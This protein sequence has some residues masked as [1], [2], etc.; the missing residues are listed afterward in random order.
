MSFYEL[1]C[2]LSIMEEKD[3]EFREEIDFKL[4][5]NS[6]G[7]IDIIIH[8]DYKEQKFQKRTFLTEL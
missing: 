8:N 3:N 2:L 7:E 4:Y 1:D 5:S 6:I